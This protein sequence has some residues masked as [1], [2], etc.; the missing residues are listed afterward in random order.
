MPKWYTGQL[1]PQHQT[2]SSK[3]LK[4]VAHE[5]NHPTMHS[6]IFFVKYLFNKKIALL[7]VFIRRYT[8]G[9]SSRLVVKLSEI[10]N[11]LKISKANI[12]IKSLDA[13]GCFTD[14]Q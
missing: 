4:P 2:L 1:K 11:G 8:R 6:S 9:K 13:E 12:F 7:V 5:T 3:N 10:T 14:F